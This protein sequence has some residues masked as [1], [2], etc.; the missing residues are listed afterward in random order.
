MNYRQLNELAAQAGEANAKSA[1]VRARQGRCRVPPHPPL[2]VSPCVS[3][4]PLLPF[5][6]PPYPPLALSLWENSFRK[7]LTANPSV[8]SLGCADSVK[9]VVGYT[10]TPNPEP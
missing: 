9:A 1:Q 8:A 4:S 3:L 2:S 10:L 5:A 6:P 7:R